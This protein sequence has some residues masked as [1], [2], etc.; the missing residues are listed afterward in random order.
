[1][2]H[3]QQRTAFSVASSTQPSVSRGQQCQPS[4]SRGQQCQPSVSRGQQRD[5]EPLDVVQD[6]QPFPVTEWAMCGAQ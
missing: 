4:V 1:V 3:G 2:W 5:R 6:G